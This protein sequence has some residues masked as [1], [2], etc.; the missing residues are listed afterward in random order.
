MDL[1]QNPKGYG[2]CHTPQCSMTLTTLWQA[3]APYTTQ[4]IGIDL[5]EN[6][7]AAYNARASH[8]VSL[9]ACPGDLEVIGFGASLRMPNRGRP[10][11]NP[12]NARVLP[13]KRCTPTMET[14]ASQ[15]SPTRHP[16]L[17]QSSKTLTLPPS[18][19]D[20]ITLTTRN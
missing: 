5:S 13:P 19:L 2:I 18:D 7:V 8:Q 15:M 12:R 10:I 11:A 9:H 17:H 16:S 14:S 20:F 3:L 4:C 6:M 1:C